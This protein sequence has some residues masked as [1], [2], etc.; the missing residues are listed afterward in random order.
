MNE[1]QPLQRPRRVAAQGAINV[2]HANV[3][4]DRMTITGVDHTGH[5]SKSKHVGGH[6]PKKARN[7]KGRR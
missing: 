2:K 6:A 3:H 1:S 5:H 7:R 4:R